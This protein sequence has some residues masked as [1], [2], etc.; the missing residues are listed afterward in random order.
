LK[1]EVNEQ[2]PKGIQN[3]PLLFMVEESHDSWRR[4]TPSGKG[5]IHCGR[6]QETEN[7]RAGV[8]KLELPL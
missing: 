4:P 2:E 3:G 6:R 5:W 8:S 7:G 1:N